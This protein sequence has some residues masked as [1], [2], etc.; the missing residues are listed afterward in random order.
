METK[1]EK[2]RYTESELKNLSLQEQCNLRD[3]CVQEKNLM[4]LIDVVTYFFKNSCAAT[5]K[6]ELPAMTFL[7]A[8]VKDIDTLNSIL[9]EY[10]WCFMEISA[11]CRV[12]SLR[13]LEIGL[14][15]PYLNSDEVDYLEDLY[16]NPKYCSVMDIILFDKE[17][18]PR[19][20]KGVTR[21]DLKK[22]NSEFSKA[23]ISQMWRSM[24]RNDSDE[25]GYTS[26]PYYD[27]YVRLSNSIVQ[28]KYEDVGDGEHVI[29][30]VID[31][32]RFLSC[33]LA[34][35][36]EE[37]MNYFIEELCK[38]N[39]YFIKD[40]LTKFDYEWIQYVDVIDI[41]Q[42]YFQNKKEIEKVKEAFALAYLKRAN[43]ID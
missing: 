25:L 20:I 39:P 43:N 42:S 23:L 8:R 27:V 4:G 16:C 30:S 40:R 5:I 24:E 2:E 1:V 18:L 33:V 14:K 31:S 22:T 7:Y 34:E 21:E 9:Q 11:E 17:L 10:S 19:P 6:Y 15:Y 35:W 38:R 3:R 37:C 28:K 13:L 12:V 36:G 32:K 29:Q 26:D 41:A